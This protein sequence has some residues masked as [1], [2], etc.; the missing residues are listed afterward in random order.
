[1]FNSFSKY[2]RIIVVIIGLLFLISTGYSKSNQKKP[3][4]LLTD[5]ICG[6]SGSANAA[7]IELRESSVDD[8]LSWIVEFEDFPKAKRT[9]SLIRSRHRIND[10][11]DAP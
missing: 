1:M 2:V 9:G 3:S 10:T 7:A 11:L 4:R 6:D 5:L 8:L